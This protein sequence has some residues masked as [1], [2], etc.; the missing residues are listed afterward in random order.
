MHYLGLLIHAVE[1]DRMSLDITFSIHVCVRL[2]YPQSFLTKTSSG[3]APAL[4]QL[5][6][7]FEIVVL[8][9]YP[10]FPMASGKPPDS[11]KGLKPFHQSHVEVISFRNEGL[12]A[13]RAFLATMSYPRC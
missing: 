3:Q 11:V 13:S 9:R 12:S 4:Y 7:G 8:H 1:L 10:S 2:L 5:C 6:Q